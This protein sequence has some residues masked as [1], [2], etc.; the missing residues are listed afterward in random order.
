MTYFINDDGREIQI[1][2]D[3][4]ITK[5]VAS[6][7]DFKIKGDFSVSFTVPNTSENRETLGYY[8]FNQLNSPVF[9]STGF[10]LVKNGNILMRGLMVI[11]E[12]RG[13]E[14]SLYFISGNSN[15]FKNLE[16]NCRDIRTERYKAFWETGEAIK[17][18]VGVTSGIVFPCVDWSY[19]GQKADRY[20][21]DLVASG[22]DGDVFYVY[23]SFPCLYLHTLLDEISNHSGIKI[24]GSLLS[25]TFFNTLILTPDSPDI[26]DP[27]TQILLSPGFP[28]SASNTVKVQ[29]VAPNMKAIDVLKWVCVTFS[30]VPVYDTFSNTLTLDLL[31]RKNLASAS[32]WSEYVKSYNIKYD[33]TQNNFLTLPDADPQFDSYNSV[34]DIRFGEVNIESPKEDGQTNDLYSSPFPACFDSVTEIGSIALPYIPMYEL[35]DDQS[36]TYSAVESYQESG[37]D[38]ILKVTGIGFPFYSFCP[39]V[40]VRLEDNNGFYDGYHRLSKPV[41]Q[42]QSNTVAYMVGQYNLPTTTS[43]G[44]LYTQKVTKGKPGTRVLSF[45]PSIASQDVSGFYISTTHLPL[46]VSTNSSASYELSNVPATYFHKSVTPY[47]NLNKYKQGLSYGSITDYN[48]LPISETYWRFLKS[49]ITNPTIRTTMLLPEAEFVDF[50]WQF[51]YLNTGNLNGYFFVDSIVNYKDSTTPVEVNLLSVSNYDSPVVNQ[52]LTNYSL[53]L[54]RGI[55]SLSGKA[56]TLNYTPYEVNI[57]ASTEGTSNEIP[58]VQYRRN[59]EAV[60]TINTSVSTDP[61]SPTLLVTIY[62][63]P[64]DLVFCN[65]KTQA[66]DPISFGAANTAPASPT[67]YCGKFGYTQF[68]IQS[69]IDIYLNAETLIDELVIC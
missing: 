55:F 42:N 2:E 8:G 18:S 6:F 27:E 11:E 34:N 15:W 50:D 68:N 64:G 13:N 41:T 67:G 69:S 26:Y 5:Q 60:T 24:S 33:Q 22:L 49:M 36:Y 23:D 39:D 3:I 57:Y 37:F 17:D 62:V 56:T 29:A 28:Q 46:K 25:D 63:S 61:S 52:I 53:S 14:L 66:G 35:E 44:Y 20:F 12:D 21:L 9:S 1:S 10:N 59:T 45:I 65:M 48:D 32:D 47:A 54:D 31:E 16:F 30:V 43:S 38:S 40:I 7:K 51:I 4:L 58:K 19:K